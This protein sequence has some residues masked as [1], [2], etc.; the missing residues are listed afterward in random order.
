[1]SDRREHTTNEDFNGEWEDG[2]PEGAPEALAEETDEPRLIPEIQRKYMRDVSLKDLPPDTWF[3]A[4]PTDDL[5]RS[6]KAVGVLQPICVSPMPMGSLLKWHVH[7]G[8]RR[9]QAAR[10]AGHHQVPALVVEQDDPAARSDAVLVALNATARPNPVAEYEAIAAMMEQ[11]AT[12]KQIARDAAIPYATVVRRLRLQDLVPELLAALR[13]GRLAYGVAERITRLGVRAQ[14]RL[15][16]RLNENGKLTGKDAKEEATALADAATAAFPTEAF[17]GLPSAAELRAATAPSAPAPG[18]EA[19]AEGSSAPEGPEAPERAASNGS[20]APTLPEGVTVR[21]VNEA[22]AHI[23]E[24]AAQ[25]AP[26][27]TRDAPRWSKADV[28]A[29]EIV[30]RVLAGVPLL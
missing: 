9:I 13:D 18:P 21:D 15:V 14:L 16:G 30:A 17:A 28:E 5:L 12:P 20:G 6:V 2:G 8:T 26:L 25:A 7:G 3:V 27:K 1:M 4:R 19:P 11:G 29:A 24:R 22:I 23:L 10:A